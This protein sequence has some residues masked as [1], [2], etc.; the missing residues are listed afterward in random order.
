MRMFCR[1]LTLLVW[2]VLVSQASEAQVKGPMPLQAPALS[3]THIAFGYAGDIWIVERAGG[4]ARRLTSHAA[5][6]GLPVF[7][8]DGSEIAF[9]RNN[10]AGGPL[11]WD[12]YAV[13]IAGGEARRLTF[14]PE[15]DIPVGW[16]PDGKS[17]LFTTFRERVAYLGYRLYT[18]PKE[19][20]WPAPLALPSGIDGSFSP[21]GR[22][23]AY[24]PL[25]GLS[26][27]TWR[28]YHG[29]ATSRIQ[30]ADL[31]DGRVE[32]VPRVADTSDAEPMWVGEKIYF[33]SDRAGTS[34]LFSYDTA[35]RKVEQ[36]TRYEKYD[37]KS[38]AAYIDTLVFVRD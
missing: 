24:C 14:H 26:A 2:L 34:N 35:S 19:G 13:S 18:I 12:V 6:E 30:V 4:E 31:S 7:S 38:A 29:G 17:I 25:W 20:G 36:L 3:Q 27:Q 15:A 32:E 9:A 16:T 28:N 1:T 11:S 8:P 10:P 21:D 22:R 37:V 23:V 5:K 33:I